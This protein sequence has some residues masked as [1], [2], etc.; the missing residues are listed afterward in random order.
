MLTENESKRFIIYRNEMEI[1]LLTMKKIEG[2][3]QLEC[4]HRQRNAELS[5]EVPVIATTI[6]R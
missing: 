2:Q 3:N 6:G 1:C 5:E 4:S